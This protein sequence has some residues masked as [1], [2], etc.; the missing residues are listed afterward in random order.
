M[1]AANGSAA[2]VVPLIIDGKEISTATKFSVIS[3]ESSKVIWECSSASREDA[4]AAVEAAARAFPA[5]SKSRIEDRR[6]I[7]LK[8]ADILETRAEECRRSMTQETGALEQFSNFNISTSADLLREVAGRISAA[9]AGSIPVCQAESTHALVV[10]EP[11]G[12]VL[13]IAPW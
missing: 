10:K 13:G 8:A 11:Y 7:F 1:S 2:T 9:L 4:V 6:Q 3:P 12:V 5:W